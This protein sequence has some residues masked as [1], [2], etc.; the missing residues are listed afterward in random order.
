MKKVDL[1]QIMPHRPPML[2]VKEVLESQ[3]DR[4]KVLV[5]NEPGGLFEDAEGFLLPAALIEMTAQAYAAFDAQNRFLAGTLPQEGGGFLVTVRNFEF[6]AP[7][8]TGQ[9][10]WVDVCVKDRFLDTRIVEGTVWT[11]GKPAARGMVYIFVWEKNDS[12]EGE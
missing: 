9:E 11:G 1:T 6:L 5:H 3:A 8:R 10:V 7:V 4:A 12:R 2:L